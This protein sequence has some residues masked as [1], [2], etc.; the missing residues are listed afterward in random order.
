M[1]L[2]TLIMI[3]I[4]LGTRMIRRQRCI[5]LHRHPRNCP[6]TTP[7]NLLKPCQAWP[8]PLPLQPA[9]DIEIDDAV[10]AEA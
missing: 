4:L 10:E 3:I 1:L 5:Q 9:S 6:M 8:L 7:R 2:E